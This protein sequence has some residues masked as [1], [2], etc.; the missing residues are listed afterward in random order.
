MEITLRAIIPDETA[1]KLQNGSP[2]PLPR[3][4]F[5]LAIIKAHE[6]DLITEREVMEML[7]LEGREDLYEFFKRY[8][9]RSR[10]TAEDFE[11][12]GVGLEA[13]LAKHG[14]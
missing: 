4:L 5:E 7:G 3:R 1:A 13:L 11:R 14:R 9:V 6:T 8:D 12:E 10:F 2:T